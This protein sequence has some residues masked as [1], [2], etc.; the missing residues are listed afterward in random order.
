MIFSPLCNQ[1]SNEQVRSIDTPVF[2]IGDL[3][4]VHALNVE[5]KT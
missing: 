2:L 1:L 5:G 3:L 4:V